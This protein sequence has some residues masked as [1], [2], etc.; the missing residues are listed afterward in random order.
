MAPKVSWCKPASL[1]PVGVNWPS[2][3]GFWHYLGGNHGCC[4]G[5]DDHPTGCPAWLQVYL[6]LL[7]STGTG[8]AGLE[9]MVRSGQLGRA[10]ELWYGCRFISTIPAC[11]PGSPGEKLSEPPMLKG[12]LRERS[13][14]QCCYLFVSSWLLVATST[15]RKIY[16]HGF[17]G[18]R[19]KCKI[20]MTRLVVFAGRHNEWYL[21]GYDKHWCWH[22]YSSE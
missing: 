1:V 18:A 7:G 21:L 2:T 20:E 14:R 6:S 3:E 15:A 22:T 8:R 11:S 13:P 9:V 10:A 12:V 19:I 4:L 17:T 5:W 16:C